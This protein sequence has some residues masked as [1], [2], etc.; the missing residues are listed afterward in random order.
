MINGFGAHGMYSEA[1]NLFEKMRSQNQQPNSVTFVSVLSA[2]S[3]SGKVEEGWKY[4]NIMSREYGIVAK[5]EHFACMVDLLGRAERIGEALSLIDK[6]P[7]DP[8]ASTWGALLGACKIYKSVELAEDVAK[9]LLPLETDKSSVYVSLLNIYAEAG[10]WDKVK[11]LRL[12]FG[13]KGLHKSAGFSSIE[14]DE[15]LYVFTSKT[16]LAS[17][18]TKLESVWI[19]VTKQMRK[20]GHVHDISFTLN[21][22]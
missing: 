5:E 3:H 17:L 21:D 14:V 16:R 22:A 10:M 9:K 13:E 19:S 7:M 15:K 4:F 18:F 11:K 6:M 1:I 20:S 8:G 2:C 12:R